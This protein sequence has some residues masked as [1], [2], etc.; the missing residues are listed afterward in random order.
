M[1]YKIGDIIKTI[2]QYPE[3]DDQLD[4]ER[5]LYKEFYM[6]KIGI[7]IKVNVSEQ[8]YTI[9]FAGIEGK[10]NYIREYMIEKKINNEI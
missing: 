4:I 10:K 1:K 5:Y 6:G 2:D 9:I 8:M 3:P 7:I